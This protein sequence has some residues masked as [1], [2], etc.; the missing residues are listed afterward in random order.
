VGNSGLP[1]REWI[2]RAAGEIQMAGRAPKPEL[3]SI[4]GGMTQQIWVNPR[5]PQTLYM[6]QIL[7]Y[8]RGALAILFGALF[9]IGDVVLFGSRILAV[10]WILLLTVGMIAGAYGIANEKKWG[11]QLGVAAALAPIVVSVAYLFRGNSD[12]LLR[13]PIGLMF[14][15]ALV[16]LL[17]H[18]MSKDYQKVWFR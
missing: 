10:I 11:Y 7:M 15:I 14:D 4:L 12:F 3:A 1:N 9:S 6:A 8:F 18:P 13:D 5:Q 16:A 17:L 2:H